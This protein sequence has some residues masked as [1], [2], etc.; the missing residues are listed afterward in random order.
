MSNPAISNRERVFE[1]PRKGK[2]VEVSCEARMRVCIILDTPN[3]STGVATAGL[4]AR[5][6]SLA[7][8]LQ[9][10]GAEVS[11]VLGDRGMTLSAAQQWGFCSLLVNPDLLYG[12]AQQL[13]PFLR[14]LAPDFLIITDPQLTA[15]NGRQWAEHI[16]AR[17]I[18]EAHDDEAQLARDSGEGEEIISSRAAW[19]LAAAQ[20]ADFVT[21][22]TERE[23]AMM[24]RFGVPENRL[25]IAP[26]GINLAERTVWGPN[27]DSL[28]LLMIGNLFYR[29]NV[30]AVQ[31]L[32]DLVGDLRS[33]GHDVTARVVGRGP[34]EL[35]ECGADGVDFVG[36]VRE[37]DAVMSD[38]SLALAPIVVG[39]GQKT[40]LLDYHAAGLPVLAT[41]EATNGYAEGSPGMIVNDELHTWADQVLRLLADPDHLISLGEAGR[42]ALFPEYDAESIAWNAL[43]RY[44]EWLQMPLS[45]PQ[46]ELPGDCSEPTWLLE[47]A[48]QLGLGDPVLT[49]RQ[50]AVELPLSEDLYQ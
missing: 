30:L 10:V 47:H 19:Q 34:A 28:R 46:V 11:F 37:L 5:M 12:P 26:I 42:R 35:L 14:S 29:P 45:R 6:V 20:T 27:L 13:M 16:G 2:D 49:A 7:A 1:A 9:A 36:P 17:L 4:P 40:K 39:S 43:V 33:R 22:L 44:Q 25:L 23:A 48:N 38:V 50:P 24:R 41:T 8:S 18:Y 21:V 32:I 15:L 3:L 31:F